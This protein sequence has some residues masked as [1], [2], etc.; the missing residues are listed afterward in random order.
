MSAK[1]CRLLRGRR[2][3]GATSPF[4]ITPD[5]QRLYQISADRVFEF[6]ID[7]A[8]G[9][10]KALAGSTIQRARHSNEIAV[11]PIAIRNASIN[12]RRTP[13]NDAAR[14]SDSS[15]P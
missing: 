12:T 14:S 11:Q 15:G 6:S 7:G 10:L 5:G 2:S 4:V 8:S 9:A 13:C 1:V 3:L